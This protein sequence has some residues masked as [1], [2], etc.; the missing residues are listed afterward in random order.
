MRDGGDEEVAVFGVAEERGLGG[1]VEEA[2][3]EIRSCAGECEDDIMYWCIRF[4]HFSKLRGEKSDCGMYYGPLHL[5]VKGRFGS[6]YIGRW[7]I[8]SLG[9]WVRSMS[10]IPVC[11]YERQIIPDVVSRFQILH[12]GSVGYLSSALSWFR[13]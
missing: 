13:R 3:E 2:E 12:F 11:D 6:I 5:C 9:V 7:H 4:R 8:A 10:I 1:E